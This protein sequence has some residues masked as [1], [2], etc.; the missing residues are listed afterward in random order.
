MENLKGKTV[1]ITGGAEG[2][3]FHAGRSLAKE[4]MNV[5]LSDID[6]ALLE[7]SV[8]KLKGEGLNVEGVACDVSIKS[9]LAAAA[10]KTVDTYG[11]VHVL[12]NN[13]AV[14]VIGAQRHIT[15]DD[16][17]WILDVNI[18]GVAFGTQVFAPLIKSHGEGGHI[19]NVASVAGLNG[20]SF[21]GP[22]SASK[23]AVISLAEGWRVELARDNIVVSVLCPGFVKTRIYDSM[24]NRQQRFGGPAHFDEL[25]KTAPFL[26]ANK[27]DVVTGID[28]SIVGDR[29]VEAVKN[30]EYYVFTHPHFRPVNL[31]RAEM[32]NSGFDAAD[33]SP[34]LKDVPRQGVILK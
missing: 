25:V 7:H 1:F 6:T 11:K 13:A 32:I 22:Y 28:P 17:R 18:L 24:R 19:M 8:K 3:G 4:G 34:A 30:D 2:I 31:E 14:S 23:A 10:K 16:W 15:E 21:G 12:I 29:V 33:K 27:K 5:M 26:S 20:L 9:D